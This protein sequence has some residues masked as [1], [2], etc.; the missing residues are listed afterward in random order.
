VFTPLSSG[1]IL[2]TGTDMLTQAQLMAL[3]SLVVIAG[4]E[5]MPMGLW[6]C[7]CI[8]LYKLIMG[9]RE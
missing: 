1:V 4:D 3:P 7:K 6:A 2:L 9:V 5:M 8:V